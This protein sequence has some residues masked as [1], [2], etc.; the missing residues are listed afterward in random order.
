MRYSSDKSPTNKVESSGSSG[1]PVGR[2][3]HNDI[4]LTQRV[5]SNGPRQIQVAGYLSEEDL[6]RASKEMVVIDRWSNE[7]GC[8]RAVKPNG[9]FEEA[10]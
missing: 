5:F 8:E 6:Q 3:H 1:I 7:Y 10:R 4:K 9:L 2:S